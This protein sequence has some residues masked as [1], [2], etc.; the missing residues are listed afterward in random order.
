MSTFT[1]SLTEIFTANFT[2]FRNWEIVKAD[3]KML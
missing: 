2:Q 3:V 1:R